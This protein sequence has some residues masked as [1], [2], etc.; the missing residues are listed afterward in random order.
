MTN[1]VI[2]DEVQNTAEKSEQQRQVSASEKEHRAQRDEKYGVKQYVDWL[3]HPLRDDFRH[4]FSPLRTALSLSEIILK[5][6]REKVNEK[7]GE[8]LLRAE[9]F[10][11]QL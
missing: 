1:S 8:T 10:Y 6:M 4:E 9:R 7:R 3:E 5:Q 2:D 11:F